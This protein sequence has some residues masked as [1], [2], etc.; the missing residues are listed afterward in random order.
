MSRGTVGSSWDSPTPRQKKIQFFVVVLR[1]SVCC[2]FLGELVSWVMGG[3]LCSCWS[4]ANGR[5]GC[6][7]IPQ[8]SSR[9]VD[10]RVGPDLQDAVR[11]AGEGQSVAHTD[12]KAMALVLR[13]LA[14]SFDC[15]TPG[16]LS[17][18]CVC[19]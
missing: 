15:L 4:V 10:S 12:G 14:S 3:P 11:E 2:H 18:F 19:K 7:E 6:S 8:A 13:I 5:A 1:L 17:S 16:M 9:A